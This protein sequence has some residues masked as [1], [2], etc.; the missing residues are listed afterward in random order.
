[1]NPAEVEN[2]HKQTIANLIKHNAYITTK[3]VCDYM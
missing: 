3:E 2:K 1:M